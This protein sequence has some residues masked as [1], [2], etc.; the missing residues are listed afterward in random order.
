MNFGQTG[1]QARF[2]YPA[3][4]VCHTPNCLRPHRFFTYEGYFEYLILKSKPHGPGL[5]KDG[6]Q[7][8]A[9]VADAEFGPDHGVGRCEVCGDREC[10]WPHRK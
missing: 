10:V 8:W 7:F 1:E 6:V 4:T 9:G 2:Y 3:C 5:N